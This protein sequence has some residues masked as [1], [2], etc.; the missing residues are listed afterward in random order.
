MYYPQTYPWS[1]GPE[2]GAGVLPGDE[3]LVNNAYC[4]WFN[5]MNEKG[6]MVTRVDGTQEFANKPGSYEV[7]DNDPRD[8]ISGHVVKFEGPLKS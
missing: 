2:M 7:L 6:E 1:I 3:P 4:S 8:P 5:V